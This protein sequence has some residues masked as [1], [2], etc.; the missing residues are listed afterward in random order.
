MAGG[1]NE[2]QVQTMV[3]EK[4]SKDLERLN[5]IMET[6]FESVIQSINQLNQQWDGD[7]SNKAIAAFNKIKSAYHQ[8]TNGRKAVMDNYIKILREMVAQGY[9]STETVNESL[10]DLF[11]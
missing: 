3:V 4:T 11:K 5:Q 7:A 9:V 8:S 2:I 1:N 10:A 6:D